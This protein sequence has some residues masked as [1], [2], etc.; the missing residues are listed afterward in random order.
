MAANIAAALDEARAAAIEAIIERHTGT[1][2]LGGT[3]YDGA[4]TMDPEGFAFG[5]GGIPEATQI[6]TV[7]LRKSD[8]TAEPA[9]GSV[10]TV[11][12]R[13][14]LIDDVSGALARDLHWK[15][16]CRRAPGEEE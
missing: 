13:S 1:V 8:L 6:T 7:L 10:I 2:N 9:R 5:P 4:V 11:D 3:T 15:L 14:F 16:R 12:G